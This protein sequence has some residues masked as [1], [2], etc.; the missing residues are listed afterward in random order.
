[1]PYR[2]PK[3]FLAG[4]CGL[5]LAVVLS[6]L[7]ALGNG[8]IWDDDGYVT[9][10]P[11]L[12][13]AAGLCDIWTKPMSSSQYYPIQYYPV[14]HT[15]FWLEHHLWGNRPSGYHAVNVLLHALNAIL[16][17]RILR[18]LSVPG[19][20][21]A[22]AIFALHPVQVES[23]AWITERKNVLSGAFYLLALGSYL[24]FE[25][26]LAPER[27]RRRWSF[28]AWAVACFALALLSKTVTASLPLVLLVLIWWKR[29]SI[30]RAD[31]PPLVPMLAM[32]AVMGLVT[33]YIE[34]AHV[35][36]QGPAWALPFAER[37]LLAGRAL[38]FYAEKLVWPH[39]LVF[40]Y[41]R[42][43]LDAGQWLLY[44][45]PLGAAAVIVA[46]WMERK[47]IGRGPLA[48]VLF[49]VITLAPA[50]G[51]FNVFPMLYSY[52]ADHFQYLACVGLIALFAAGVTAALE[53]AGPVGRWARIPLW[54]VLLFSLGALTWRQCGI[55]RNEET[56]W[57]DTLRKNPGCWMAH[58]NL[59]KLLSLRG[60][61]REAVQQYEQALTIWP[62]DAGAHNNLAIELNNLGRTAE[63]IQHFE[64][65]VRLWP[66]YADA[67]TNL[68]VMLLGLGRRDEALFQFKQAVTLRPDNAVLHNNIAWLLAT[69]DRP[70]GDAAVSYAERAAELTQRRD[71]SVLD[72]LAA[73]YAAAGRFDEAVATAQKAV[74]LA[75]AN[76]QDALVSD[77]RSHLA[78]YKR[79]MRLRADDQAGKR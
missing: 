6:Y 63:A 46:L 60:E 52:V 35:G 28:Y 51:F 41:P 32:G 15:S 48:A 12:R 4:A 37:V 49:F 59:G 50:L 79:G 69:A 11:R 3:A 38:W 54:L 10:N 2:S 47:E 34:R 67:R 7:P 23:V 21:W 17:W 77:V 33:A 43:Q 8:F 9:R 72:T 40:I 74:E 25:G 22:A 19:A 36:A 39:P 1:M 53:Q 14:V 20:F 71:P 57:R 70:A 31:W 58:V 76:G 18:R 66:K 55:Y 42:W 13:D 44:L 30:R 75:A 27:A 62:Q 73:S 65:A 45:Y 26:D 24:A 5:L 29:G 61:S 16:L 78:L 64:E 56:L 68:G